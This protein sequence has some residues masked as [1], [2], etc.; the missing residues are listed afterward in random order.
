MKYLPSLYA[1]PEGVNNPL[2]RKALEYY[3]HDTSDALENLA[4]FG[5]IG[6]VMSLLLCAA[7]AM[8][9]WFIFGHDLGFSKPF[10]WVGP[11]LTGLMTLVGATAQGYDRDVKVMAHVRK[12]SLDLVEMAKKSMHAIDP[13]EGHAVLRDM[14]E[15]LAVPREDPLRRK[16]MLQLAAIERN[17]ESAKIRV[18]SKPDEVR[19]AER[20]AAKAVYEIAK[21]IAPI[22]RKAKLDAI[23]H[24]A[25]EDLERSCEEIVIGGIDTVVA[26]PAAA[27]GNARIERI[28]AN[29]E[30]AL[31]IDPDLT[32]DTGARIDDL[33]RKHVPRLLAV[34]AEASRARPVED[35]GSIDDA[36]DEGVEMVRASVEEALGRLQDAS[37]DAL[38]TEIGFLRLRR[39]DDTLKLPS[40]SDAG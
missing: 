39:G 22:H 33:V 38:Q 3:R 26:I 16:T 15:Y 23:D 17:L 35:L 24:T 1:D 13:T 6:F 36:L 31:A 25:L 11:I 20:I 37:G 9:S 32:D 40:P 4:I 2:G 21:P 10:L 18:D 8:I 28:M 7:A 29:A 12:K 14:G 5:G 19:K 27:V 34:H 30:K